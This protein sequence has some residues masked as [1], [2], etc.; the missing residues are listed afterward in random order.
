MNQPIV[1]V[2]LR[3]AGKS[4]VGRALAEALRLP[5]IDLDDE[6]AAHDAFIET[7]KKPVWRRN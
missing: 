6:L 4:S 1:I 5:F 2:G 3:C 7:L